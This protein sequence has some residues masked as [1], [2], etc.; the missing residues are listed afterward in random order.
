METSRT[1]LRK[2][3]EHELESD[4]FT[5]NIVIKALCKRLKWYEAKNLA[6]QMELSGV[7]HNSIMYGL[8]MNGLFDGRQ[9]ASLFNVV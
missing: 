7:S 3:K 8:L 4:V 1:L 5:I 6:A 2:M 9:T